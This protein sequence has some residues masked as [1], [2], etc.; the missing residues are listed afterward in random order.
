MRLLRHA[1]IGLNAGGR[2]SRGILRGLGCIPNLRSEIPTGPVSLS[3][4]PTK[5]LYNEIR[6]ARRFSCVLD[7][8]VGSFACKR[9]S[10]E[11][12]LEERGS[13]QPLGFEFPGINNDNC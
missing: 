3:P 2:R 4:K 12:V 6:R 11:Q 7:R 9:S 13:R 5:D 1:P 8:W 10:T